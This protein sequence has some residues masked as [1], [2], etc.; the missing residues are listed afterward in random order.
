MRLLLRTVVVLALGVLVELGLYAA[1]EP[2]FGQFMGPDG[3]NP[4]FIALTS[5][6]RALGGHAAPLSAEQLSGAGG[7]PGFAGSGPGGP[8]G[9][10]PFGGGPFGAGG[11]RPATP[12]GEGQSLP[13]APG[14]SASDLLWIAV[15]AL[16]GGVIEL[17]FVAL[18]KRR[19]RSA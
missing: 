2:A 1:L 9:G 6:W 10:G 4:N 15:P 11:G 16:L 18:R 8:A 7:M 14:Q 5:T 13:D 3:P 12:L 19:R 17:G